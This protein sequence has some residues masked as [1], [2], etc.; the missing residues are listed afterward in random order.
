MLKYKMTVPHVQLKYLKCVLAFLFFI[1]IYLRYT[2]ENASYLSLCLC[3]S[4]FH[5]K[6]KCKINLNF[7]QGE[8]VRGSSIGYFVF[9]LPGLSL[10]HTV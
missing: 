1:S 6:I 2:G 3:V 8:M 10:S 4:I 9:C 7:F 5:R